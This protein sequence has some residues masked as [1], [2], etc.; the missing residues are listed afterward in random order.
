MKIVA[1]AVQTLYVEDVELVILSL[2]QDGI[3]FGASVSHLGV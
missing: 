1:D 2:A 3:F